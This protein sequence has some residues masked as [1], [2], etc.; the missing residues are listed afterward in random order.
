MLYVPQIPFNTAIALCQQKLIQDRSEP[1]HHS[2]VLFASKNRILGKGYNE[3]RSTT[4]FG[5]SI[6]TVHAELAA[7]YDAFGSQTT[8]KVLHQYLL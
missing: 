5:C 3:M 1:F 2:A 7:I 4:C 6:P 8:K